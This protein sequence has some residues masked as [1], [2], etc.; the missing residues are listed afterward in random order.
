M[1][2]VLTFE[3]ALAPVPECAF[4]WFKGLSALHIHPWS[5]LRRA[6]THPTHYELRPTTD[7]ATF[8]AI[9][10]TVEQRKS[11]RCVAWTFFDHCPTPHKRL[12]TIAMSSYSRYKQH[13][14]NVVT[15]LV[16]ASKGLGYGEGTNADVE[17]EATTQGKG[18]LK[19]KDRLKAKAATRT[20]YQDTPRQY[21]VSIK[22]MLTR[23]TFIAKRA[24]AIPMPIGIKRSLKKAIDGRKQFATH[25]DAVD[26]G[27]DGHLHFIGVLEKLA[28]TLSTCIYTP[29]AKTPLPSGPTSKDSKETLVNIFEALE[30]EELE[31]G[32]DVDQPPK[33]A[34]GTTTPIIQYEPE[35]DP[36]EEQLFRWFCFIDDFY[37]VL[38]HLDQVWSRY[39]S[40]NLDLIAAT[41][42]TEFALD[43]LE[44]EHD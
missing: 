26:D 44:Q 1:A 35:I 12:H 9:Y 15:W 11:F 25:F 37:T 38:K 32:P 21:L 2:D 18:R 8:L 36:R 42:I 4:T 43:L 7:C 22:E 14:S 6:A 13:T 24:A 34:T 27:S 5:L 31:A 30:L 17:N 3:A 28:Q 40:G 19:G 39:S 16:E 33:D 29:Q 10:S 23:A 20:F 41:L